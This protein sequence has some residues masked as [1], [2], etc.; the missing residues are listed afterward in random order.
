MS[1]SN[2]EKVIFLNPPSEMGRKIIRNFDCATESKG[3]YLYQPYDFLLL[4]SSISENHELKILDAIADKIDFKNVMLRV[5]NFSPSLIVVSI[6]DSNWNEDFYFIKQLRQSYSDLCIIVI[7]DSFIDSTSVDKI[8]P[9]VNGILHNPIFTNFDDIINNKNQDWLDLGGFIKNDSYTKTDLKKPISVHIKMPKHEKF[10]SNN[11][12]WPFSH[13]FRYTTVFTAWG[14]PYSCSYCI[15]AKFP[16]YYRP[17]KEVYDELEYVKT[18]GVKEFYMGDRSFGLPR[19]NVISL[20]EKMI[21]NNINLKWSTYFHPNQYD[22]ELLELMKKSG[23]H[24]I[25]IGIEIANIKKLKQFGRHTK[26]GRLQE[27]IN[28]CNKIGIKICGDYIIGLPGETKK[29]VLETIKL[30]KSLKIDYASF[31]IAAP[32]AGSSIRERAIEEGRLKVGELEFDSF[33]YKKILGNG[34][35]SGEELEQLRNIAVRGFYF[36]VGY[37]VR[38]VLRLR[39]LEQLIIQF[40][41][42]IQLFK[43]SKSL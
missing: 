15:M 12:R 3:N 29:D 14:C 42:M 17:Y 11:Y 36:R 13:N 38:S 31:N 23:C 20:M 39:T 30:S 18:L 40:Q 5:E 28:H 35:L 9:Y 4:S 21:T 27:L 26:E 1:I 25:I 37:L 33:G 32:L 7:G 43:K 24:T 22:F 16:N 19:N 6:A 2:K 10:L 8:K 41:E 34:I